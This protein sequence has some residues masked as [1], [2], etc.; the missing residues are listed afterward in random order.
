MQKIVIKVIKESRSR[1]SLLSQ[2]GLK[3]KG[4]DQAYISAPF[5]GNHGDSKITFSL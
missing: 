2:Q 4:L 3:L 5:S 1:S